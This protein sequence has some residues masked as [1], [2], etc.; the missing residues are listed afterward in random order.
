MKPLILVTALILGSQAPP[1]LAQ[2]SDA[3]AGKVTTSAKP[4]DP[5]KVVCKDQ[6]IEGTRFQKRLCMTRAAWIQRERREAERSQ[7]V[8]LSEDPVLANP[9]LRERGVPMMH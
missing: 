7:R 1:A 8:S 9:A 2:K 5:D 3:T 6:P 4:S